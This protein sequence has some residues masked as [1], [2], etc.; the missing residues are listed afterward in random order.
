MLM[1]KAHFGS[2]KTSFNKLYPY[3]LLM[4]TLN[5]EKLYTTN[6]SIRRQR[7]CTYIR[8]GSRNIGVSLP[9]LLQVSQKTALNFYVATRITSFYISTFESCIVGI[10]YPSH[11]GSLDYIST[12]YG[13]AIVF[14]YLILQKKGIRTLRA[15][16]T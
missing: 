2:F 3:S 5:P 12:R 4:L 9:L 14:E 6:L 10:M 16:W 7:T 11:H 1:L 13:Y 8:S 15:H